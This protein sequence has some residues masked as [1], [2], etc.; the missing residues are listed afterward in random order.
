MPT[1]VFNNTFYTKQD[2]VK[3]YTDT[4]ISMG[5]KISNSQ[6]FGT[7]NNVDK[8]KF[9][10]TKRLLP[11]VSDLNSINYSNCINNEYVKI[12]NKFIKS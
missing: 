11:F 4:L 5:D 2:I 3:K 6:K 7:V 1:S 8:L 9:I 12:V 10:R